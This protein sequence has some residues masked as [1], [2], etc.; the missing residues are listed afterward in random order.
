MHSFL[1]DYSGFYGTGENNTEGLSLD[2]FLKGYDPYKYKTPC[3]TTDAVVFSYDTELKKDL[4]GLKALFVKRSN[5]PCIGFWALPGGFIDMDE[6]LEATAKRELLEE[7]GVEDLPME[8]FAAYGDY[9]R[10]PRARIITAAYMALVEE[11]QVTVQAG[12]D[13]ADAAWC[14]VSVKELSQC[15]ENEKVVRELEL[16]VVNEEKGIDTK[17]VVTHTRRKGLIHEEKYAVKERGTVACDHAALIVQAV[18]IL[19]GRLNK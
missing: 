5:H 16:H 9:D 13:A 15:E 14:S 19:K 3:C 10:D 17:A 1:K 12:D 7:T 4:T 2:E 11:H 18:E 8:Q 6:D